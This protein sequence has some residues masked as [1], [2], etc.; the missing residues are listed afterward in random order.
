MI[1]ME[2]S[3]P[4]KRL[5]AVTNL[6]FLV[7]IDFTLEINTIYLQLGFTAPV[8]T[9]EFYK[10]MLYSSWPGVYNNIHRFL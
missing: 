8:Y 4:S 10:E 6:S 7:V 5:A 1:L 3:C 2:A 9:P